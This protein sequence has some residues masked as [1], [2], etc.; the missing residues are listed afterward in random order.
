MSLN[1]KAILDGS[2]DAFAADSSKLLLDVS[3][4]FASVSDTCTTCD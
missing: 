1:P 4:Y 2:I 3:G